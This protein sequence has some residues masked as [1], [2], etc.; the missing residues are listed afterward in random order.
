MQMV[1]PNPFRESRLNTAENYRPEWDVPELNA[2][3]S[4]W[5][6]EEVRRLV[7]RA[8]PDPGQI[9]AVITGPPGYG[10]T[11]LFGRIA[12][13]VGRD[14][15]F[16]FVPAFEP[17]TPPLDHIRR[18]VVAALFR[19]IG[20]APSPAELALARLCGP[21]M[22]DYF[23]DLPPTLAARHDSLRQRLAG[24]P[25]AVL[26]IVRSVKAFPPFARLADSLVSVLPGDSGVVRA[27]ALGWAPAPWSDTARRWLQGQDLPEA[28]LKTVGLALEP[29]TAM[30]VLKAIPALFGHQ[31]PMMICCDQIEG[32]LQSEKKADLIVTLSQSLMDL[33]QS[34]P[35]QIVLSCFKDSWQD[36]VFRNTLNAF[37]MRVQQPIF[38]LEAM[39]P[40]QAIRLIAGRMTGWP[41]HLAD[42]PSIW[43]FAEATIRHLVTRYAPTPRGLIQDCA[44]QFDEW[45]EGDRNGEI[46]PPPTPGPKPGPK[47]HT[48]AFLA[49]WAD[50][51]EEIKSSPERAVGQIAEDRLYRGVLEALKLA[52]SAQRSA[53][54]AGFGLSTFRI[55]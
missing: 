19:K 15:F 21:A 24:S 23:A 34:L 30:N 43:P 37:Q 12:A 18:H 7:G 40:N 13:H 10:K 26:E 33:L 42:K 4:N 3:I 46:T 53:T 54:S 51:I 48:R 14:V 9:I 2:T 16:V 17:E 41:E 1:P 29:S 11:H 50:E 5:L 52:H 44:R 45:C 27:L 39:K 47:D 25:D 49:E 38:D 20:D 35:A 32:I 22:A 36:H 55:A 28:D 31:Q 6:V 8:E